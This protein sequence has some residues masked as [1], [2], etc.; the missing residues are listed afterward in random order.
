M[1]CTAPRWDTSGGKFGPFSGHVLIGDVNT[2][3]INRGT[4]EK[5][6]GQYQGAAYPFIDAGALGGGSNRMAFHPKT[7]KLYVGQ[8]ARGWASGHG[9][10]LIEWTGNTSMGLHTV[11]LTK[12]G[13]KI[14]FTKPAGAVDPAA[15]K[16]NSWIYEYTGAYGAKRLDGKTHKV[17]EAKLSA[18]G[19]NVEI[20]VEG[21]G[22]DRVVQI[23]A[24]G[25]KGKDGEVMRYS[26]AYYTLNKMLE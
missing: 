18:D 1:S 3:K 4:L 19:T 21:L 13:F 22:P 25:I 12:A 5:V 10:K 16:I 20:T 24:S 6:G 9:L 8:T 17:T 26:K 2:P 11:S 15:F 14:S 23:D 7:G